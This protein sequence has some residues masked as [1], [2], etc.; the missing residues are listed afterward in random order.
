MVLY[1]LAIFPV[2]LGVILLPISESSSAEA[3]YPQDQSA[4]IAD[5]AHH[6]WARSFEIDKDSNMIA[7]DAG[8]YGADC[9]PTGGQGA[10][11]SI[12]LY[13]K[14]DA[15]IRSIDNVS[16]VNVDNAQNVKTHRELLKSVN[17][18]D[19]SRATYFLPIM[20]GQ[21]GC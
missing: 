6:V 12:V 18:N 7:Y 4:T 5:Q 3:I 11:L 16:I 8:A 2:L 1:R 13:S 9:I 19:L 10:W 20:K 15:I 17:K 14:D 21:A